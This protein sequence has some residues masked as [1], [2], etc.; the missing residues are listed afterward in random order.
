MSRDADVLGMPWPRFVEHFRANWKPG[1]HVAFIGPTGEG[2]STAAGGLLHLRKYVLAFDPKGGDSTLAATGF[3]RVTD[4]DRQTV[5]RIAR[6][7]EDGEPVRLIV[8]NVVRGAE[9]MIK[10]RRLF[11]TVLR[12]AFEHGGWTVYVDELQVL[13]DRRLMNLSARAEQ[14]LIA[15]RDRGVS[16]VSSFQRPANVP[17]TAGDQST[18]FVVFYTRDVDVVNR[19]AEMAGRPK[20]EMRGAI[21]ALDRHYCLVFNRNP[22]EPIIVT[23]ARPLTVGGSSNGRSRS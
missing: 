1:E 13:A 21:R 12:S 7:I 19:L 16:F 2:K 15:A 9:D 14:L 20:A 11:D 3:E 22:R 4:W 5:T 6:K 10:L 18:W 8:G 23:R 17:R